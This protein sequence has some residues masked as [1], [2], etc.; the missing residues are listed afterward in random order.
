MCLGSFYGKPG[1]HIF[2]LLI[3]CTSHLEP[4][5]VTLLNDKFDYFCTYS[6]AFAVPTIL[7]SQASLARLV[8]SKYFLQ[9]FLTSCFPCVATSQVFPPSLFTQVEEANT[10]H[11]C[12]LSNGCCL[13]ERP[14]P[15]GSCRGTDTLTHRP[16]ILLLSGVSL[17]IHHGCNIISVCVCEM[18]VMSLACAIRDAVSKPH[19]SISIHHAMHVGCTGLK[20]NVVIMATIPSQMC[21]LL[22]Q[23]IMQCV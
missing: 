18:Y 10:H 22:N 19:Q 2:P 7:I 12:F 13:L 9:D 4:S 21:V 11:R 14:A 16:P 1:S 6:Q 5:I 20:E 8:T 23:F 3:R 15:T 17:S